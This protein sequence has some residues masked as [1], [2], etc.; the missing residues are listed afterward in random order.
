ML[1]QHVSS[2]GRFLMCLPLRSSLSVSKTWPDSASLQIKK[3]YYCSATGNSCSQAQPHRSPLDTYRTGTIWA[4]FPPPLL[5]VPGSSQGIIVYHSALAV[6]VKKRL[7]SLSLFALFCIEW[8]HW[9]VRNVFKQKETKETVNRCI[10]WRHQRTPFSPLF[11]HAAE[12]CIV[13]RII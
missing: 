4:L 13:W 6:G 1:Q 5:K 7:L 8:S 9:N 12:L 11:Q 10:V 2:Q 3:D